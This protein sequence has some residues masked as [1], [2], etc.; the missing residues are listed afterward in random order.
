[1]KKYNIMDDVS[2]KLKECGQTF[3]EVQCF[4]GWFVSLFTWGIP[5]ETSFAALDI[6]FLKAGVS[7]KFLFELA[8]AVLHMEKSLIL[9]KKNEEQLLVFFNNETQCDLHELKNYKYMLTLLQHYTVQQNDIDFYR[10][11]CS[12]KLLKDEAQKWSNKNAFNVNKRKEVSKDDHNKKRDIFLR[13]YPMFPGKSYI[14]KL[15][16]S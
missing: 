2:Q 3:D 8:L 15:K 4:I 5:M 10:T 12:G 6:F 11:I 13:L 1:M 16:A 14:E 7:N 9:E